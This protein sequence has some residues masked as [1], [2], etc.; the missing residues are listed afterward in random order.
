[1]HLTD[2]VRHF[3]RTWTQRVGALDESFL[4][5]G[6]PLGA[7]RLLFEIGSAGASVRELRD[8]MDLD[9][10]YVSR[11]LRQLADHDLVEVAADPQDARRRT[12]SLTAAGRRHLADLE[13]R[14]E[15]RAATL[16]APLSERQRERF[17]AALATADLLVRAAT[18]HLREVL[19]SDPMAVTAVAR[20]VD[21]LVG[22]FPAGFDPG[23]PAP[24]A[25]F[26]PARGGIFVV[27]TSDGVPVACGGIQQ[28]GDGIGEV[29]RMW[30]DG[31]WRGAGLGA[32]M[33][34]DLEDR[35]VALGHHT[36][37]LDTNSALTEAIALY[38][39]SGYRRIERYNDNPHA[40]VF[41]EKSPD[42]R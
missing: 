31:D 35:A 1:M 13:D 22:R 11:L 14:S 42:R 9:S 6:L 28:I 8:R 7:T 26:T 41:F 10:G 32:R 34:R 2:V 38:D 20:Y 21:E 29:K 25:V 27:A 12:A 24:D 18:I 40:E 19:P 17:A 3:N 23:V 36:V 15:A 4:G 39:R 16:V 33:L 37:R 5:L 30:V